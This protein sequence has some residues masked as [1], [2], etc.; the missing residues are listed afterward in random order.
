MNCVIYYNH[1]TGKIKN[2]LDIWSR[3]SQPVGSLSLS[4]AL[5]QIYPFLRFLIDSLMLS[6]IE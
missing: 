6:S 3:E 5:L 1:D 4:L 2:P